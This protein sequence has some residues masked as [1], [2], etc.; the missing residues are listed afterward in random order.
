MTTPFQDHFSD[1]A[2]EYARYRPTYPDGLFEAIAAAAPA[3]DAA[4]DVGCGNGQASLALAKYF[5]HVEASDA[6]AEQIAAATPHPRVRYEVSP[7]EA[8][9]LADHSIDAIL[10]AQALHW[11]DHEKFYAAVRRVAKANA[12][13][14]AVMYDLAEV[15]PDIDHVIHTFYRGAIGPYWPGDR[16]HIDT[17]YRSIAWPFAPVT[18]MVPPIQA[19]WSL[20]D[21]LHY[22]GTWSAVTRFK[23][24]GHPDPLPALNAE[25]MPLWAD[26]Q[27]HMVQWPLH[28]L[29]G[30]VR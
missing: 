19:H 26:D 11:F 1:H 5:G 29:A 22:I 4:W 12:L 21:L 25:L 28:T 8:P 15:T 7:A 27:I 23:A 9:S 24:D 20:D 10:I 30:R 16:R 2:E 13:I 17:H 14:V 18:L 3:R 6:S